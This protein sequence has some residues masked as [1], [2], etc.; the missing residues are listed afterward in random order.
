M[1]MA[2]RCVGY[3]VVLVREIQAFHGQ[4]SVTD[5][6]LIPWM[7]DHDA[8]WIHADDNAKRQHRKLLVAHQV[9]T[10][11]VRRSKKR[12]MSNREQLRVLSYVLPDL[13]ARFNKQP[14]NRHHS[15]RVHGEVHKTRIRLEPYRL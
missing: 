1:G 2:L 11:W 14:G 3:D 13:F 15:V 9:R 8:I 10:L 7:S 4:S 12:G 5:Q 6:Q